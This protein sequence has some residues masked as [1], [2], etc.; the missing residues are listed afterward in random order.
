MICRKK[1]KIKFVFFTNAPFNLR[2]KGAFVKKLKIANH[3]FF[4]KPFMVF[5]FDGNVIDSTC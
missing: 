2:I 1:G 3:H 4:G 5:Y